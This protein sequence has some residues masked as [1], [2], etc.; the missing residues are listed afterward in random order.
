MQIDDYVYDVTKFAN[1]H[2]GGLA[3]L[4]MVAGE[5]AT[6]QFYALHNKDVLAKYHD[7]LCIGVLE[8]SS[9]KDLKLEEATG[10]ELISLVP[11]A[12]IPLLRKNW[13]PSPWWTESHRAFLLDV[14][15][16]LTR[17]QPEVLEI[18]CSDSPYRYSDFRLRFSIPQFR[19]SVPLFRL[20]VPLF[21]LSVPL[22]RLSVPLFRLSVPLF[23]LSVPLLRLSV[24]LLG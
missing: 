17:M 1:L 20:S 9:K 10:E 21:R 18:R 7:K 12:E 5:D 23:R 3:V 8:D 15:M 2:P 14:R 13:A 6:K 11:Y 19:L 22:F 4:R 16:T 24:L